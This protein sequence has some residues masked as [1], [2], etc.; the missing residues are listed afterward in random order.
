MT[1]YVISGYIGFDNFGDEAI[2]GILTRHLKE[3]GAEKITVISADPEKTSRLYGVKSVPILEFFRP[4]I[5]AD[6]LISGGGSLLQDITSLKS[7]LYYIAVIMAGIAFDKKVYIFAQGFAPFRTKIGRFLTKIILKRCSKITVRDINSQKMLEDMGIESEVIS[8]PVFAENTDNTEHS[9]I[10]VQLRSFPTVT[11][12]FLKGLASA[13][14]EKF[15]GEKIKLF[16]FQDSSDW[17][18][19]R[20]FA[21]YLT[22]NGNLIEIYKDLSVAE[23]INEVSKL[24][25]LIAMRF[26]ACLIAAKSGVKVLGINYD[27]KVKNL[28]Q[29]IGFPI[30]NMYGCE[31]A[32]GIDNL[33]KENPET[34]NI[35]EF[36]FPDF[37][38]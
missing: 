15:K 34:Y 26:H 23:C 6:V 35:P 8:D 12:E 1:K 21:E 30:I 31:A 38:K 37:N 13:I 10:G 14:S 20:K 36:S 18:V 2:C 28:A 5:E 29:S 27:E 9:G 16:S 11:E 25:Y 3:I 19:I 17:P 22:A 32:N 33:I 24:E 7:L 4:V